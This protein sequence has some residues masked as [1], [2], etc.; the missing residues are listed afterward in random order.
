MP[1]FSISS[2]CSRLGNGSCSFHPRVP[3]P[4]FEE[5]H[6]QLPRLVGE[7]RAV[8][9]AKPST[10]V[11]SRGGSTVPIRHQPWCLVPSGL[12]MK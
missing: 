7:G 10:I 4:C 11:S 3:P 1:I 2:I 9:V 5:A 6:A 12:V 8:G